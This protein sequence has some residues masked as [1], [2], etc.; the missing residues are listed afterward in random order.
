MGTLYDMQHRLELRDIPGKGQGV[1]SARDFK[2]GDTISVGVIKKILSKN[3]R[4]ATQIGEKK[5]VL[6]AG[7]MSRIN[8][9]CDPNCGIKPNLLGAY[10]LIALKNGKRD[11][12]VT[13]DYALQNYVIDYFTEKCA[14]GTAICREDITGW[15][16]L[17]LERRKE[18]ADF[19]APYLIEM[20]RRKTERPVENE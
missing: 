19:V 3:E 16:D 2:A 18:Y 5:F 4:N 6:L 7:L 13:F 12:E 14:C 20:D 17:P 1:F 8:H 9:S 10:D 11:E 15:R